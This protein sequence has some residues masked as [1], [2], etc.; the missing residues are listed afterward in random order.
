MADYAVRAATLDDLEALTDI[1]NH[2]VVNTAITFDLRTFAAPERR[3]WFDDH[4]SSGPHRLLVATDARNRCLGYA[5]SSRWRPKPAY[6]TTVETSVYCH[7]EALGRGCGTALYEALFAALA[8]EDV[9]RV[10][11]GVS[12][13]NPASVSL[14]EK[15]G[16]RPVGVF[17][18]VGRKFD[19]FWDV[20]WFERPLRL[21]GDTGGQE[22]FTG[23]PG[24]QEDKFKKTR[25]LIS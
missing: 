16:F 25:V 2:Y 3:A 9:H 15:F 8:S 6:D 21:G 4:R 12:L 23:G 17:H 13:P 19:R 1:Y 11:A 14:H 20:A 24:D 7:P 10:V 22:L 5:S 18:S